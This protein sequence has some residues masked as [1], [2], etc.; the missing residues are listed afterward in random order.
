MH[1]RH[2]Q[3]HP[4]ITTPMATFQT[5]TQVGS[6][7]CYAA[8]VT[9]MEFSPCGRYLLTGGD[10]G[11]VIF[12]D[13]MKGL[14]LHDFVLDATVLTLCWGSSSSFFVGC[15]D[16]T[17]YFYENVTVGSLL[18]GDLASSLFMQI[19][20]IGLRSE[21]L[22]GVDAPIFSVY[23]DKVSDRLAVAAGSEVQIAARL[24]RSASVHLVFPH[25]LTRYRN[26]CNFED[27]AGARRDTTASCPTALGPSEVQRVSASRCVSEPRGHVSSSQRN[28]PLT[29]IA[30]FSCWDVE[31]LTNMWSMD[32]GLHDTLRPV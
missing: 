7:S 21:V 15:R 1:V 25:L 18:V 8:E 11:S 6:L 32:F 3:W 19:R 30:C 14:H 28:T 24:N 29:L 27:Y 13:Y 31:T 22:I 17:L 9:C 12:W 4:H 5:Y 26:I 23:Y 2:C 20:S 16:G 10:D